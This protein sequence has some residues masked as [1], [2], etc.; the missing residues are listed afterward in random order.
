[1]ADPKFQPDVAGLAAQLRAQHGR[2]AFDVAF[3]TARQ[4]MHDASWKHCTMWLQVVN[5]LRAAPD[6]V[7]TAS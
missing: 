1:M 3:E 5:R 6:S 7:A 4:H 2:R